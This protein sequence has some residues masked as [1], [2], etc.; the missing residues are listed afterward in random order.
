M[1]NFHKKLITLTG[2][3]LLA[4]S[5]G[6]A[7]LTNTKEVGNL[8]KK[9][10]KPK[11][12]RSPEAGSQETLTFISSQEGF[13]SEQVKTEDVHLGEEKQVEAVVDT[14]KME[15]VTVPEK[16]IPNVKTETKAESK[17]EVLPPNLEVSPEFLGE[18]FEGILKKLT[19]GFGN[20]KTMQVTG[21]GDTIH[22]HSDVKVL[23][24]SI[25]FDGTIMTVDDKLSMKNA[26]LKAPPAL[27]GVV[28][29]EFVKNLPGILRDLEKNL[30]EKYKDT[31]PNGFGGFRINEGR[32][33]MLLI[34]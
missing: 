12:E 9:E 19:R 30:R 2:A 32:L 6:D 5:V 29:K 10:E 23:T 1:N 22:I 24:M 26:Q 16:V 8:Q 17:V 15:S 27:Q 14:P 28:D 11:D 25:T 3:A 34:K 31:H 21:S 33:K 13:S 4:H 18:A 20:I 7:P